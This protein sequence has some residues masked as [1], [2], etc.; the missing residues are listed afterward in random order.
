MSIVA[1]SA[2]VIAA[3]GHGLLAPLNS[4]KILRQHAGV[5]QKDRTMTPMTTTTTGHTAVTALL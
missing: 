4:G 5:S 3:S 1:M 2:I